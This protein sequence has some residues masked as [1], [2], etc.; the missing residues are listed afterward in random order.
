MELFRAPIRPLAAAGAFA[1][2]AACTETPRHETCRDEA[3]Q[4]AY[5]KAFVA[6]LVAAGESG[7]HPFS[8]TDQ[9]QLDLLSVEVKADGP[10]EICI[11]ID[12]RRAEL[13]L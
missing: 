11:W 4:Q 7:K 6:D 2:L 12:E 1:A 3:S 5:A 10:A 8:V 13:G 9:T